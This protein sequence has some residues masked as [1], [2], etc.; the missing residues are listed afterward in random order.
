MKTCIDSEL[1]DQV[2]EKSTN[3][4]FHQ[5]INIV[6]K[7]DNFWFT[8]KVNCHYAFGQANKFSMQG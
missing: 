5:S 1:N 7:I 8:Y 3:D 2:V 6:V 4:Y